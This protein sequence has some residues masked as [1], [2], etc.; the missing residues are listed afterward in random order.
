MKSQL[1][2]N[3]SEFQYSHLRSEPR[4]GVAHLLHAQF[5][6]VAPVREVAERSLGALAPR[7]ERAHLLSQALGALALLRVLQRRQTQRALLRAQLVA[8][9]KQVRRD[10]HAFRVQTADLQTK[11]RVLNLLNDNTTTSTK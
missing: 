4:L 5:E 7:L 6:L 11:I 8:Q 9:L 3:Q 1:K 10:V 2:T